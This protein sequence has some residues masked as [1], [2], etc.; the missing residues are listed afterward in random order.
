MLDE[1]AFVNAVVALHATGGSTNHAIHL[2]A[3]AQAAGIRLTWDDISDLSEAVPLLARVYPNGASDVNHFAAAG[4]T[5]FVIGELL[6]AGMLHADVETVM[7]TGLAPY[8]AEARLDGDQLAWA[9]ALPESADPAVLRPAADPFA[10]D[11]GL[12]LQGRRDHRRHGGGGAFPGPARQWD[13]G[14]A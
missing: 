10:P 2:L 5:G 8:R 9:P 4:G 13:A 11:G 14:A 1:R 7:G 6:D 12:R 3:M